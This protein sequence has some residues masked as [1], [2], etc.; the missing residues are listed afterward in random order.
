MYRRDLS[1]AVEF[2]PAG[3]KEAGEGQWTAGGIEYS[4]YRPSAKH[5]SQNF[6]TNPMRGVG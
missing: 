1:A 2:A 5:Y 6:W 4:D 3:R